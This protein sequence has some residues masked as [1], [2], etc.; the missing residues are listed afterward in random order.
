MKKYLI[1]SIACLLIAGLFTNCGNQ[2]EFEGIDE[3]VA[4]ASVTVENITAEELKIKLDEGE[5]ILIIDVREHGEYIY[6]YIPGAVNISRGVLEF[7]IGNEKFWDSQFLYL[8]EKTEEIIIYCKKGRRGVLAV[9]SL[10]S[11]GYSNVKNLEGGWKQWEM[12][13]PLI[14][15][16]SLEE[17]AHGAVEEEGG[18]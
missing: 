6:G 15:E 18:C 14:Y 2:T 13:F 7:R 17:A 9:N 8:P 4:A 1:I 12:T 11:L 16:K 3:M 10:K 5:M